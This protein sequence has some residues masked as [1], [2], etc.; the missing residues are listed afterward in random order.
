VAVAPSPAPAAK[1]SARRLFHRVGRFF[2]R[3]FGAES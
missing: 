1:P 3:L 2:S